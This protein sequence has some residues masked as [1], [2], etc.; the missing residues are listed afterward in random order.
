LPRACARTP[1]GGRPSADVVG[2][3]DALQA[4]VDDL[5]ADAAQVGVGVLAHQLHDVVALAGHHVMHGALAEFHL[6]AVGDGLLQAPRGALLVAHRDVVLLD[7]E[8]APLDER[9]HRHRD[10]ARGEEAERLG[11]VV[12]QDAHVEGAHVLHQRPLEVQPGLGDDLLH[13][14]QLED[15]GVLALVD[16]EHHGARQHR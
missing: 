13:L 15:D 14:A 4:H 7:V 3:V 16:G 12:G 5:D 2:Q 10:V 9:V 8:N 6:Q 1:C 11:I